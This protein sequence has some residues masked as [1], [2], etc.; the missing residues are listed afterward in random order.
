MP[1]VRILPLEPNRMIRV[2]CLGA[3]LKDDYLQIIKAAGFTVRILSEDKDI[4][5][6]Q[7]QGIALESLKVEARK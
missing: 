3:S 4:S 1:Q 7:Y 2:C 5:K 6:R